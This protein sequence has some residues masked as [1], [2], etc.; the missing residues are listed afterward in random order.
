MAADPAGKDVIKNM[1]LKDAAEVLADKILK[2]LN[3]EPTVTNA[4]FGDPVYTI[5]FDT[6]ELDKED[7]FLLRL[8]M[9]QKRIKP[10]PFR[11]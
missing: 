6:R 11:Q 5:Q 4:C 2:R 9:I 3:V 7:I 8:Q 10:F 1:I